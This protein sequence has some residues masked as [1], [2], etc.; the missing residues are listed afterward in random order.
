[1]FSRRL[2]RFLEGHRKAKPRYIRY[3]VLDGIL[4]VNHDGSGLSTLSFWIGASKRLFSTTLKTS[5][6][7]NNGTSTVGYLIGVDIS[8][9]AHQEAVKA[10]LST[11]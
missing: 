9:M 4:L 8:S 11:L 7:G 3:K 10:P 1:M 5:W 6:G 2:M